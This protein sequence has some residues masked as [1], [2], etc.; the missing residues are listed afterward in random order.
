[1]PGGA[2]RVRTVLRERPAR[3]LAAV[4]VRRVPRLHVVVAGG[5]H[6][7]H[8]R[9][10]ALRLRQEL[11]PHARVVRVRLLALPAAVG[12]ADVARVQM[13]GGVLAEDQLVVGEGVIADALVA[14]GGEDERLGRGGGR[15]ERADRRHPGGVR[16]VEAVVADAVVVRRPRLE[17]VQADVQVVLVDGGQFPR[18]RGGVQRAHLGLDPPAQLPRLQPDAQERPLHGERHLPGDPHLRLRG[19][20]EGQVAPERGHERAVDRRRGGRRHQRGRRRR[21]RPPREQPAAGRGETAREPAGQRAAAGDLGAGVPGAQIVVLLGH[22]HA[23]REP[24][25]YPDPW[26]VL[27]HAG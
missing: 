17:S 25:G 6:P 24:V 21:A 20:A 13:E 27:G 2:R 9:G 26:G 12:V 11:V 1:M 5:D 10:D 22:A 19:G 8:A 14:E 3:G 7:R 4:A 16:R 18:Q 15:T 23:T